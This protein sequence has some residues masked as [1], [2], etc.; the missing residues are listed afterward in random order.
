MY[1]FYIQYTSTKYMIFKCT[2]YIKNAIKTNIFLD[3]FKLG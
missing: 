2:K 3:P 1:I